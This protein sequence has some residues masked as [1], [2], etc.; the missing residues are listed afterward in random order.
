MPQGHNLIDPA[1]NSNATKSHVKFINAPSRTVDVSQWDPQTG[2]QK[3]Y[4]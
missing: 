2:Q 3:K 1:T 4:D